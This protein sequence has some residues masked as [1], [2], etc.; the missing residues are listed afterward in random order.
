MFKTTIQ[1][2]HILDCI[3]AFLML[4][5]GAFMLIGF[6]SLNS[7]G[8]VQKVSG[9]VDVVKWI[10]LTSVI[11]SFVLLLFYIFCVLNWFALR[12]KGKFGIIAELIYI[13]GMHTLAEKIDEKTEEKKSIGGEVFKSQSESASVESLY[14]FGHTEDQ[15]WT[16]SGKKPEAPNSIG[17]DN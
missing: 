15:K 6:F 13:L 11:I 7:L 1:N 14:G 17:Y 9:N 16:F 3:S 10:F 8:S 2:I 4:I 12:T 5:G